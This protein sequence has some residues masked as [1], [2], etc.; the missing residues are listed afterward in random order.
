MELLLPIGTVVELG[1]VEYHVVIIGYGGKKRSN[2]VIPEGVKT[3]GTSSF[4]WNGITS[5]TFPSTL[6]TIGESAF[7]YNKLSVITIPEKVTSIGKSAFLRTY[8]YGPYNNDLRTVHNLSGNAFNWKSI[9]GGRFEANF[10]T[11]TVQHQQGNIEVYG[12]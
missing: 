1:D 2:I 10:A 3:L 8:P 12:S 6:E 4:S 11:G 9:F 5:V 7:A